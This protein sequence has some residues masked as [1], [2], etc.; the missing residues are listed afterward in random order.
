MIDH[1]EETKAV[2]VNTEASTE[3]SPTVTNV[4]QFQPT[5][6]M[7]VWLD[8]A[9]QLET[10]SITEIAE[11]SNIARKTWYDWLDKKGFIEWFRATWD[12]KLSG[13]SWRLDAIGMKN[14]KR[15]FKYWESM[16]KRV[17]NLI[18]QPKSLQQFNV[19]GEMNVE[20]TE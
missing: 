12:K 15:D 19:S 2:Q 7:I 16:Q 14:A 3:T 18:E 17:G 8:T 13:Q 6:H 10:D 4:A 1:L 20:F 9:I 5:P 11:A